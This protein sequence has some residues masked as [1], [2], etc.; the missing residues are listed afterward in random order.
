[1]GPVVNIVPNLSPDG[2]SVELNV[3]AQLKLE[4][5]QAR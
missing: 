4:S 5:V 1:M 2:R 3:I